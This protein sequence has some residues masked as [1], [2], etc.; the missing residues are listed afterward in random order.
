MLLKRRQFSHPRT[1]REVQKKFCRAESK[2]EAFAESQRK[3]RSQ[4]ARC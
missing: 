4:R 2:A 3:L 1:H